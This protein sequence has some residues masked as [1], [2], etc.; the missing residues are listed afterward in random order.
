[1]AVEE[2]A[3]FPSKAFS[4]FLKDCKTQYRIGPDSFKI[5]KVISIYKSNEKSN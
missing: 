4:T 1:M 3:L 5:A 2:F